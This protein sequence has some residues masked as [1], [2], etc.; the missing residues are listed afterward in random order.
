MLGIMPT[1]PHARL[2]LAG[3]SLGTMLNPLNSTMITVAVIAIAGDLGATFV[4][5]SW[6]VT[7]FYLVSCTAQPVLGRFADRYGPQ[8]IF[9][10]GMLVVLIA[11]TTENPSFSVIA[12]LVSRAIREVFEDGSVTSLFT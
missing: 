1:L 6:V 10:S 8:R 2:V 9:V 12:P 5:V 11:A 7:V 4:E 3:L